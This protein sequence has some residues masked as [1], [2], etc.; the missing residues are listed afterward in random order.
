MYDRIVGA[1]Y[2]SGESMTQRNNRRG[3]GRPGR[4]GWNEHV[5]AFH[6]VAIEANALWVAAGK[7]RN[8][9]VFR[10]KW[11]TK[12]RFKY[13]LRYIKDNENAMRAD[14]LARKMQS[15]NSKDFWK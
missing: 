5:E 8:G 15:L 7:P 10:Y 3:N 2:T 12:L 4:P 9:D 13:A 6:Q 1:L 11:S 14:S